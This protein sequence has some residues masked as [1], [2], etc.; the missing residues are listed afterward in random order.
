MA[1]FSNRVARPLHCL[2]REKNRSTTLRS[3]Y[4]FASSL[5]GCPPLAPLRLRLL[6]W[7]FRSG[8]TNLIPRLRQWSRLAA[9][10]YARSA[11]TTSGR[12][13]GRPA[14]DGLGTRSSSR[15]S[16]K[17][18]PSWR[19]PPV[20]MMT[21]AR[22]LPSTPGMCFRRKPSACPAY[23]VT[24]KFITQRRGILAICTSPLCADRGGV[25]WDNAVAES[26][27]STLK[28]H[29]MYGIK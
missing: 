14:P 8:Q 6:T 5:G 24:C 25:Y 1:C 11:I 20:T 29:L 21:I 22:P 10:E 3:L 17:T 12:T 19:C 18:A 9:D 4:R 2:A 23:S 13:R 7:P 26:F 15:T 16:G 28:L 27:F